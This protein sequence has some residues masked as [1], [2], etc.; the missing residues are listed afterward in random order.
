VLLHVCLLENNRLAAHRLPVY[1]AGNA[2]SCAPQR[3][4]SVRARQRAL[5]VTDIDIESIRKRTTGEAIVVVGG[6]AIRV[7]MNI[8]GGVDF[9]L[10][11]GVDMA[12]ICVNACRVDSVLTGSTQRS[13]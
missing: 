12:L 2:T 8:P 4:A 9:G 3:R 10:L 1:R 6:F 7:G 13:P 11:K 5:N